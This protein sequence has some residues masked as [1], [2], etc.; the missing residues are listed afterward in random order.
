M[1]ILSKLPTPREI[2]NCMRKTAD[3]HTGY[4]SWLDM[5]GPMVRTWG[6]HKTKKAGFEYVEVMRESFSMIVSK[7]IY[8]NGMAGYSVIYESNQKDWTQNINYWDIIEK[9]LGVF[10]GILNLEDLFKEQKY[11]YCAYKPHLG[12]LIEYLKIYLEHPE[13]EHL[14]KLNIKPSKSIVKKCQDKQFC[15]FLFEHKDELMKSIYTPSELLFAYKNNMNLQTASHTLY[16]KRV[17]E[18]DTRE[19]T[20]IKTPG[21]DRVRLHE[22]AYQEGFSRYRDYWEAINAL[23]Y[24]ILDTK[25]TYPKDFE[26]MH[27]LRIDEYESMKAKINAKKQRQ[28]SKQIEKVAKKYEPALI[29]NENLC[30]I[31]PKKVMDF[32]REGKELHHCVGKM[33]YDKKMAEERSLIAFIRKKDSIE[34]PYVTAEIVLQGSP[35]LTQLYGDHDSRPDKEVFVFANEFLNQIK[36]VRKAKA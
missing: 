2:L 7:N 36:K 33:G 16:I 23:G 8:F 35:V 12:N 15:R 14:A 20:N 26:R 9:P 30:V 29:E 1:R 13:I 34:T 24:D 27:D 19:W 10:T 17:A 32:K 11:K 21:L 3:N 5:K 4:I 31:F 28:F 6:F 22:F 25:N 18:K